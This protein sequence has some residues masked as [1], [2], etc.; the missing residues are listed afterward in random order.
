MNRRYQ[1][2]NDNRYNNQRRQNKYYETRNHMNWNEIIKKIE[3]MKT[4]SLGLT[5]ELVNLP[6]GL[7]DSAAYCLQKEGTKLNTNQLRKFFSMVK[8]VEGYYKKDFK[9]ALNSLY[10]VIPLIAYSVGRKN[11]P[12]IF[13]ELMTKCITPIKIKEPN[14]IE[15]LI[16]F[17][18]AIV[19]YSKLYERRN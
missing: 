19:A 11:C 9:R 4:L 12:K 6:E 18:E 17:L 3:G 1:S 2:N 5:P 13:Y 10:L 14:D 8:E 15:S 16:D 7:A